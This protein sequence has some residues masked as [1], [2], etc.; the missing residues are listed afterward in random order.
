M[1]KNVIVRGIK[2]KIIPT[3]PEADHAELGLY[4]NIDGTQEIRWV[5]APINGTSDTWKSGIVCQIGTLD[6]GIRAEGGGSP[7]EYSGLSIVVANGNRLILQLCELGITLNGKTAELWEFEGTDADADSISAVTYFRGTAS[8]ELNTTWDERFWNIDITNNRYRRNAFFG[9]IINNDTI[10]GNYPNASDNQNGKLVP[11]TFGKFQIE[12]DG[13][14]NPAKFLRVAEKKT[15]IINSKYFGGGRYCTPVGLSVFPVI[16]NGVGH[17]VNGSSTV[18]VWGATSFYSVG[19]HLTFRLG[20]A[21]GSNRTILSIDEGAGTITVSGAAANATVSTPIDFISSADV[22]MTATTVYTIQIGLDKVG[23]FPAP[24]PGIDVTGGFFDTLVGK[25]LNCVTGG[26]AD[27]TSMSG[28]FRKIL[29]FQLSD[30]TATG[31][32]CLVTVQI[33]SVF[34]KNLSGATA[35]LGTNQAWVSIFDIPFMFRNDDWPCYGF[36]DASGNLSTELKK[37]FIYKSDD[38]FLEN[39][40]YAT[41]DVTGN[42]I[43]KTSSA[44]IG[45]KEIAP[46]G[47]VANGSF[48]NTVIIDAMHFSDSPDNLISFD[49]IPMINLIRFI[50]SDLSPWN[51]PSLLSITGNLY[52]DSPGDYSIL[53][54]TSTGSVSLASDKNDS[55][56]YQMH[57]SAVK[58]GT[59]QIATAYECEIDVSK[60]LIPYDAFYLGINFTSNVT[61]SLLGSYLD[62]G[63]W[64]KRRNFIGASNYVLPLVTGNKLHDTGSTWGRIETLPDFYYDV[65][66]SD[67]NNS[68]F[69]EV[70]TALSSLPAITGHTLVP[71]SGVDN[72]EA[73][74]SIYKIGFVHVAAGGT[75]GGPS[76]TVS[77]TQRIKEIALICKTSGSISEQFFTLCAGRIFNDTWGGR[78]TAASM[79]TNPPDFIEHFARL[80]WGGDDVR[81]VVEYGKAYSPHMPIKTGTDATYDNGSFDST[82]LTEVKTYSPAWQVLNK[83]EA[84]TDVQISNLCRTFD[85][86]VY[87]D[88]NG[89]ICITTLDKTNP[90]ETITFNDIKGKIGWT[91][92]QQIKNIYTQPFFNY[93]YN[94]GS[95]KFDRLMAVLNVQ[96]TSYLPE[97]TPGIDNTLYTLQAIYEPSVSPPVIPDGEYTWNA[98][99]ALYLKYGQIERCPPSFSDQKMLTKYSD[100]LRIFYK[101]II[102]QAQSRQTIDVSYEKGRYYHPG[103]HIKIKLPHQTLNLS[104]EVLIEKMRM[105]KYSDTIPLDVLLL[106]DVPTAFFFE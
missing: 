4:Q 22:T 51:Y 95:E 58:S 73:I 102:R 28:R 1:G 21:D 74:R 5:E 46:F 10:N 94:Y 103:K 101:K 66:T 83:E 47:Y 29:H 78:K 97:Y 36:L 8:Y 60:I 57:I 16:S 13:R 63:F 35:A 77:I 82:I 44:P 64:L 96:A 75:V 72:S 43:V 48:G 91:R 86:C 18:F 23:F 25:W 84:Y 104:V 15:R 56:F 6:R 59:Y 27:G 53:D 14:I 93:G 7:E 3:V 89:N 32:A 105:G 50:E 90:S 30:W 17:T 85:L 80:Q 70:N 67:K 69:F 41:D 45:F 9:T 92:P 26:S 40:Q 76:R 39:K 34:E 54:Y 98:C 88:L 99:R 19:D 100:A 61:N 37:L 81:D 38:S 65:R 106:E 49:I 71:F 87:T 31:G 68:F 52:S 2:F 79:V 24:M 20:F 55:T 33:A 12:A 11:A 62:S 42:L